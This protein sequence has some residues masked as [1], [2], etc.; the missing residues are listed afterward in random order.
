M[1]PRREPALYLGALSSG[2]S[3]LVALGVGNLTTDQAG[4]VIAT[5]SAVIG[6]V[7]AVATRP[8]ALGVFTTLVG[9]GAAL[10]TAFGL[11]VAPE[12]VGAWNAAILAVVTLVVRGQVSP[13]ASA[14]RH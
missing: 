12:T 7:T 2:L 3:L 11:H 13:A 10:V 4:A 14:G 9:A 5:L 8:I 6:V 1:T